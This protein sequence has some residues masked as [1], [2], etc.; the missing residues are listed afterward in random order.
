MKLKSKGTFVLEGRDQVLVDSHLGVNNNLNVK[1]GAYIEGEL[2]CHHITT[3]GEIQTTHP[4]RVWGKFNTS[5]GTDPTTK[6]AAHE[7]GFQANSLTYFGNHNNDSDTNRIQ[8]T[9]YDLAAHSN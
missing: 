6:I 9:E 3:P 1:G 5:G 2:Y 4:T 8:I 7:P